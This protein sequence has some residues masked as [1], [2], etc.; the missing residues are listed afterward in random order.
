MAYRTVLDP[1]VEGS[2]PL[3][4]IM[5]VALQLPSPT[6]GDR[7]KV[8]RGGGRPRA[9]YTQKKPRPARMTSR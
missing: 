9:K 7:R 1:P 8:A 4:E 5:R 6:L 2:V 3:D